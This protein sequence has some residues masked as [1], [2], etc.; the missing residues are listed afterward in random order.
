MRLASPRPR[1]PRAA[2]VACALSAP[3]APA[4][5]AGTPADGSDRHRTGEVVTV[6]TAGV[7]DPGNP[8]VGVVPF[9]DAVYPDCAAAPATPGGCLTVGGVRYPYEIGKLEVTVAQWVA[10]LNT[11]DPDGHDRL[12]LWDA[13]ESGETWPR[14]G[15]VEFAEDARRGRHYS[16]AHPEWADKPYG[17]ADFLDAARFVNSLFNGRVLA[18]DTATEGGFTYHSYRVRLSP[19]TERGMYDLDRPDTTRTA[20]SGFVVPSQNE[21]V[22]A[23]YYDPSGGGTYSYWKYPTNAGVFGDGDATAPGPTVLDPT[24][25]DVTNASIRPLASY[26]PSGGAAPTWCPGQV[27]P[28]ECATVNPLGLDPATYATL[29]QGSLST[30]GQALSASPWGTFDQGGNAVEWTDTITPPPT[31]QDFG[32]V[33]RRLHGGVSN[34]PAYQLWPSAVGLQPQD[35]VF[36][37]HTYPWLGFRIGVVGDVGPK[38]P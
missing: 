31:G 5:A 18:K 23:A 20:A 16:L 30:G 22:K 21:W 26:H 10:F 33:W 25:G 35:N 27:P 15:Q 28:A 7:G 3:L 29:Y 32:R 13:N 19:R 11:V 17:F 1:L 4:A 2:A 6:T 34:A 12:G 14:Y 24:T 9:T 38:R 37:R 36:Y 8:P